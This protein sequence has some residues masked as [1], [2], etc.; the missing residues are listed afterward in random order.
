MSIGCDGCSQAVRRSHLIS[1]SGSGS[2]LR[3]SVDCR[4]CRR[5]GRAD[6]Q[7]RDTIRAL[8]QGANQDHVPRRT[9]VSLRWSR[10]LAGSVLAASLG[11]V[12]R[13]EGTA[14]LICHGILS[15]S[16]HDLSS[17]EMNWWARVGRDW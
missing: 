12:R 7:N 11:C 2:M 17:S 16:G 10:S 5:I 4:R 3:P 9:S 6:G 1:P 14:V 8:Y 13:G 15:P